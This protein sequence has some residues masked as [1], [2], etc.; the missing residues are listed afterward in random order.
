MANLLRIPVSRRGEDSY[1]LQLLDV[2]TQSFGQQHSDV[3]TVDRDPFAIPHL[4]AIAA[5][6]GRTA[7]DDFT[8]ELKHAFALADELTDELVTAAAVV[9]ATPMFN[10]GPPSAL[11]A[12]IDRV[13]NKRTFYRES[14][15]LAGLP[16]TVIVASGGK[17]TTPE[18]SAHDSLGPLLRQ[19][20]SR[21]GTDDLVFIDCEP[22]GP[23]DHGAID[24]D[25]PQSGFAQAL[26]GIDSAA[27]RIGSAAAAAEFSQR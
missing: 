7:P 15:A 26:A 17:Y 1:S 14:P 6:A 25:D 21:I 9:I 16:V 13:I 19:C 5:T 27:A 8:P 18:M 4:D 11:K 2:F 20:F 24:R 10:W 3:V 22:T 23:I 12:W